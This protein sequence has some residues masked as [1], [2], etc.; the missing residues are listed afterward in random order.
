MF[1]YRKA[2]TRERLFLILAAISAAALPFAMYAA[3][4]L[5]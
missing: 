2:D 4:L 1:S 3:L 5:G